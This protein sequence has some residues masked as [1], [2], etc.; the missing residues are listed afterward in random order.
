MFNCCDTVLEPFKVKNG[1][2]QGGILSPVLFN[3]FI[4]ELN[5]RLNNVNIGCYVNSRPLNHLFC[6]DDSVY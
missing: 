3:V 2:C 1:V 5:I 4:D 6:A